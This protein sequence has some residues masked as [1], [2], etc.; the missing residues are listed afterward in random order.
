MYLQLVDTKMLYR[1]IAPGKMAKI[2][3]RAKRF[4]I[5]IY[6]P[7]AHFRKARGIKVLK[8]KGQGNHSSQSW[9]GMIAG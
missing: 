9:K 5:A 1:S 2:A 4:T 7:F 3:Q 6:C 8:G